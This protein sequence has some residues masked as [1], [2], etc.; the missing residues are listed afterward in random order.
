MINRIENLND[1]KIEIHKRKDALKLIELEIRYDY[2]EIS[3]Y[4][5]PSNIVVRFFS[6]FFSD[7][8]NNS[9][10]FRQ[11][12]SLGVNYFIDRFILKK[13]PDYLKTFIK[14]FTDNITYNIVNDDSKSVWENIKDSFSGIEI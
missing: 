10:L 13:A 3:E 12:A 11:T 5:K 7:K 4:L 1:L 14:Y 2:I 8:K 9:K 6:T